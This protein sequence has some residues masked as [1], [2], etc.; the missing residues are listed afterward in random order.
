MKLI[1]VP[2]I[3]TAISPIHH[4]GNEKTGSTIGFR[5]IDMITT[6]GIQ[7]V[8]VISG[9]AIKGKIRRTVMKDFMDR[10]SYTPSS[11]RMH[12]FL[13]AGGN[14]EAVAAKDSGM[15]NLELKRKVREMI[16][17]ISLFGSSIANQI[18]AGK[19]RVQMAIP[20]CRELPHMQQ[21]RS[22]ISFHELMSTMHQTRKDDLGREEGSEGNPQQMLIEYEIMIPGAQYTHE[23]VLEDASELEES[24]FSHLLDLWIRDPIVGG[25]SSIGLG[26]M[27]ALYEIPNLIGSELYLNYLKENADQIICILEEIC[28]K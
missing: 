1:R 14:L 15:I 28:K 3:L 12:H 9:N 5:R 21:H 20:I 22:N 8:P 7:E 2:G 24:A 10:I 18:F 19:M 6:Q 27:N 11:P 13:Y 25:K 4:G 17:M 26:R 23:F 16:P